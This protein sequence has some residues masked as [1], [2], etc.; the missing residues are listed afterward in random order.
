MICSAN[1]LFY[2]SMRM[3]E[4]GGLVNDISY[5]LYWNKVFYRFGYENYASGRVFNVFLD[6]HRFFFF[7]SLQQVDSA[8]EGHSKGQHVCTLRA[9]N[10]S[11]GVFHR[12]GRRW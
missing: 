5:F 1:L 6:D 7:L 2:S 12:L 11:R 3:V 10:R 8:K 9:N 4:A